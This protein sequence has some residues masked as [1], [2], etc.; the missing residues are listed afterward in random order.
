[1][2][3]SDKAIYPADG[4]PD[5]NGGAEMRGHAIRGAAWMMTLRWAVRLLSIANTAILAR[6]LTPA[7]FGLMAMAT[8]ALSVISVFGTSGE[9]LALIRLGRPARDYLDSA[10]T[11]KLIT[12]SIL[13]LTALASAPLARLYFH[14]VNVELLV[15][16]I[17]LRVLLDGF[18]NVGIVYFRIDLN[19]DI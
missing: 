3:A 17:S 6:L 13:F 19:L 8:L 4:T 7:D 15:Y 5:V 9:D 18:I 14:S 2:S 16:L 11:L 12:S 1:M 10:W